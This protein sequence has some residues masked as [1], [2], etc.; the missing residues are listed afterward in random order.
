VTGL[1]AYGG[2]CTPCMP[3]SQP[4]G[5][6]PFRRPSESLYVPSYVPTRRYDPSAYDIRDAERRLQ[7]QLDRCKAATALLRLKKE[8]TYRN[9]PTS[10]TTSYLPAVRYYSGPRGESSLVLGSPATSLVPQR[11]PSAQVGV[12]P[13]TTGGQRYTFD[14]FMRSKA[15]GVGVMSTTPTLGGGDFGPFASYRPSTLCAKCG[16]GGGGMSTSLPCIRMP[17]HVPQGKAGMPTAMIPSPPVETRKVSSRLAAIPDTRGNPNFGTYP[18]AEVPGELMEIIHKIPSVPENTLYFLF[19]VNDATLSSKVLTLIEALW[20][21]WARHV[22]FAYGDTDP[23]MANWLGL[24]VDR[25]PSVALETPQGHRFVMDPKIPL[26]PSSVATFL[27]AF[28]SC[29]LTPVPA[30]LPRPREHSNPVAFAPSSE[31]WEVPNH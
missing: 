19:D 12:R 22:S 27:Q 20:N 8:G 31:V 2:I 30:I 3:S 6:A 26:T 10:S 1:E 28:M 4:T 18:T 11:P 16:A 5:P 13:S 21:D 23:D 9:S 25:F 7:E 29:A 14:Y 24:V 17:L 15:S